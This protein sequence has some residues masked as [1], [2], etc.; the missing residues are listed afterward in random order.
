LLEPLLL[1]PPSTSTDPLLLDPPPLAPLLLDP[2]LPLDVPELPP[3]PLDPLELLPLPDPLAAAPPE[4]TGPG[5]LQC[6]DSSPKP[7][8]DIAPNVDRMFIGGGLSS[9]KCARGGQGRVASRGRKVELSRRHREWRWH[10]GRGW[11]DARHTAY[12][13]CSNHRSAN[14]RQRKR[15]QS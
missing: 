11:C 5:E 2:P 9:S 3:L 7:T 15:S 6:T 8:K 10:H 13:S 1:D 14:E 12:K 4:S